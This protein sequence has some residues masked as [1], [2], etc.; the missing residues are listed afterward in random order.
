ML[1]YLRPLRSVT[2]PPTWRLV[3]SFAHRGPTDGADEE[4]I[5]AARHFLANLDADTIRR[6][7][8]HDVSFSRSSGP[9]GQNVNKVSSKATLRISLP[10]LL[11]LLPKLLHPHIVSSRYHAAKTSDVVIQADDSRK[12]TDN[13]ISCFRRL[14]ELIVEAGRASVPGET[15]EATS[16]RVEGLQKAEKAQR[17]KAKEFQSKK[18]GARRGGGDER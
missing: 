17:R 9:G 14:H 6:N 7:A 2:T 13:V 4:D 5:K 8:P 16:K 15:S 10:S 11:P 18:K 1:R 12:Q 3:R